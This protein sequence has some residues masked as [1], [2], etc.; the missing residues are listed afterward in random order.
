M[1]RIRAGF[2]AQRPGSEQYSRGGPMGELERKAG[3]EGRGGPGGERREANLELSGGRESTGQA[4]N[5][6]AMRVPVDAATHS[7]KHTPASLI[8]SFVEHRGGRRR[9]HV[10]RERKH[11]DKHR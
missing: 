1:R 2:G 10:K 11:I 8:G 7:H 4:G 5:S 3:G 9:F 6:G